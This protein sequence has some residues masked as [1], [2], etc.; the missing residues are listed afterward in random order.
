MSR[1]AALEPPA[2][3]WT[4]ALAALPPAL[5]LQVQRTVAADVAAQEAWP[6]P[7]TAAAAAAALPPSRAYASG[8]SAALAPTSGLGVFRA[9][10][11]QRSSCGGHVAA[12]SRRFPSTAG[13]LAGLLGEAA[14]GAGRPLP[15]AAAAGAAAAATSAASAPLPD[16]S[17]LPLAADLAAHGLD[18]GYRVA[19]L[20]ALKRRMQ[21]ARAGGSSSGGGG[22]GA[23]SSSGS[24]SGGGAGSGGG[25]GAG[26]G[27]LGAWL[28]QP[29]R[30]PATARLLLSGALEREAARAFAQSQASAAVVLAASL[31]LD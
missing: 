7:G 18:A 29:S 20:K 13:L 2:P 1:R 3:T 31:D 23:G 5:R 19:L 22:S 9:F 11:L 10:A 25:G 12:V 24:G 6:R 27:D 8:N 26:E 14:R 16:P 17:L 30:C 28:A 4:E 21:Q 15:A